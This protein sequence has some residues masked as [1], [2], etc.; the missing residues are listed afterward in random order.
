VA[1]AL[2]GRAAELDRL[3][4]LVTAAAGGHGGTALLLGEAGI[5][6]TRLLDETATAAS[7]VGLAVLR[8]A[9]V[10]GAGAYR[11]VAEAVRRLDAPVH[12]P[13]L[14]PYLPA[15]GRL[16]PDWAT[17]G[18]PEP[19]VDPALVLGE[20][21]LRALPPGGAALLLDDLHWADA[22][23]VALVAYLAGAVTGAPIA[24]VAAARDE[25][26][27]TAALRA[28]VRR[29][30]VEVVRLDRLRA[31]DVVGLAERRAGGPLR[32]TPGTPWWPVPMACRSWW[33]RSSTGSARPP[34]RPR[35]RRWSR[36]G[37]P[38]YRRRIAVWSRP[39]RS[40]PVSPTPA[41]SRICSGCRRT[42]RS[43]RCGP[44]TRTC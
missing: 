39:P 44:R 7:D 3:R 6:K 35:W 37:W 25:E 5:G 16:R 28:L 27:A 2:V 41:F 22:D 40:C 14:R 17:P 20:G 31:A 11:A 29:R 9:A 23:T 36:T 30:D 1:Q 21:L 38:R 18:V 26:P 32:P 43:T 12:A 34:C 24:I 10:D 33:R 15:L 8:G 4:R 19:L 42:A 13:E